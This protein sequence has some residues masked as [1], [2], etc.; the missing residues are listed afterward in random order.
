M[1]N[2]IEFV[3]TCSDNIILDVGKDRDTHGLPMSNIRNKP[4]V[5]VLDSALRS[6]SSDQNGTENQTQGGTKI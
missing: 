6:S 2:H 4:T 3:H 5:Q 1:K